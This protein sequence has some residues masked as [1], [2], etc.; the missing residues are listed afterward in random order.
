MEAAAGTGLHAPL[1]VLLAVVLDLNLPDFFEHQHQQVLIDTLDVVEH[2]FVV[3]GS[4]QLFFG[5]RGPELNGLGSHTGLIIVGEVSS[6]LNNL[7]KVVLN[8]VV[9]LASELN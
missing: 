3:L 1:V 6:D 5:E 7:F 4:V 2:G 8:V 9:F